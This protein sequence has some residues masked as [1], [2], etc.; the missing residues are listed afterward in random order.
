MQQLPLAKR[1]I[2]EELEKLPTRQ[3]MLFYQVMN[4]MVQSEGK[5]YVFFI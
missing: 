3:R 2:Q 5:R 1:E 4:F